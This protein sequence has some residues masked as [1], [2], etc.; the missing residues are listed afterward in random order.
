MTRSAFICVK[1]CFSTPY[2]VSATLPR[3]LNV[4]GNTR[5]GYGVARFYTQRCA[6][7]SRRSPPDCS[8]LPSIR[9]AAPP[10]PFYALASAPRQNLGSSTRLLSSS[11]T[12]P[13]S[14][15]PLLWQVMTFGVVGL[16]FYGVNTYLSSPSWRVDTD[17]PRSEDKP[18]APQAEITDK[19]YFDVR[20]GDSG[21]GD[22]GTSRIVLGLHGNIAPKTVA[23]FVALCRG[24]TSIAGTRLSYDNSIFHR[25]IPG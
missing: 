13:K 3:L 12:P 20:I 24:D 18:V 21:Q 23:N 19:V 2:A 17:G 16:T 14:S 1:A 11:A 10:P 7:K 9:G 22:A 15:N 8:Q 25:I 4:R 6:V 5:S